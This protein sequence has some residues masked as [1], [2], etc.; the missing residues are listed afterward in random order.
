MI[1]TTTA[2][3]SW[4]ETMLLLQKESRACGSLLLELASVAPP[5]QATSR[6][7]VWCMGRGK[8]SNRLDRFTWHYFTRR[9]FRA[10]TAAK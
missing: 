9:A 4:E 10:T 1:E 8:R 2:A 7:S 5:R 6:E 3:P